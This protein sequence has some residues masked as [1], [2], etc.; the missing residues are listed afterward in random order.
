LEG[1]NGIKFT[2]PALKDDLPTTRRDSGKPSELKQFLDILSKV[3]F[4]TPE[5]P[6]SRR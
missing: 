6:L 5:R 3:S 1:K 2:L 4:S